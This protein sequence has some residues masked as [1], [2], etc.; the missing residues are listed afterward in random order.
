MTALPPVPTTIAVPSRELRGM[1]D[2]ALVP[3][4]LDHWAVAR[5]DRVAWRFVDYASDR[6][7]IEHAVTHAELA[8]W[9]RAIA[10]RLAEVTRPGDRVAILTPPGTAYA[11]GF[12]G[13]LRSAAV[14][15][16]LFDPEHIGQADRLRGV[17]AD[18]RPACV[19]TVRA[20]RET[21]E[22][23]VAEHGAH[24]LCVDE[25]AGRADIAAGYE[26]PATLTADRL[27]Y[28]QYTS[29]STRAPAGVRLT[30]G[31]L[32]AN[33]RQI[34]QGF[35]VHPADHN[36]GVSW[37]PLFHDMGL[38]LG[39]VVPLT[40]G[41]TGHVFDPLAFIQRP[42]RWM[43]AIAEQPNPFTAAPNFAFGYAAKRI[44]P[45]DREALDLSGVRGMLNG[46][47]P[48]RPRTMAEFVDTFSQCGL[49]PEVVRP[50]YGLA[51]A[52]VFVSTTSLDRPA[53]V[54]EVDAAALQEHRAVPAA[55]GRSTAL[56]SCGVPFGQH[57]A[58]ADPVTRDRC[59]DGDVGEIWVHGPN[60]GIGYWGD[61]ADSSSTFGATLGRPG[62]EPAHGWLRTGD[63]GVIVD[64]E[65]YITGRMKD[66]IIVDGRNIYPNDIEATVEEAHADIAAHRLAAFAV[67][68]GDGEGLV[69]VAERHRDAEGAAARLDQIAAAARHAV[70]L[71]HAVALFD[72]VLVDPHTVPR[73]SSGKIARQATRSQYLEGGLRRVERQT[74]GVA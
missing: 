28:L 43:R 10:A 15:V 6:A 31:N 51:E 17:L 50:S 35:G 39:I 29:G 59:I 61:P 26:R 21:V 18:C 62:F 14:G 66:T 63:L 73:T 71:Q 27:A 67:S 53:R 25:L 72:F 52:T 48:V 41:G 69:V 11:A 64:G 42:I 45:A 30:Q 47:E 37:L 55:D 16:P 36:T 56:V 7:G 22:A 4:L 20:D 46:A 68:D 54:L 70:S 33:A 3:D 49:R 19:L 8:V 44:R 57:V 74:G 58:I 40:V 12:L 34:A 65:L 2:D 60:V 24:V 5:P 9:S 23:A 38:L 1:H 32:A 13:T